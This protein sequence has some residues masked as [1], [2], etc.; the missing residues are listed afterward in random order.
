VSAGYVFAAVSVVFLSLA[1]LRTTAGSGARL[2]RRIW[3]LMGVIFAAV[4]AW[5][6]LQ[7]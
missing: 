5:L 3:L 4:S 1:A 7:G 2:Q 6:L